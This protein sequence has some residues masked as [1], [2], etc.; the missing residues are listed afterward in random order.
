MSLRNG[1][2]DEGAA[3]FQAATQQLSSPLPSQL[4]FIIPGKHSLLFEQSRNQRH[5]SRALLT[6]WFWTI[7]PLIPDR[8]AQRYPP[9]ALTSANQKKSKSF[10]EKYCYLVFF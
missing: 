4:L 6:W 8:S 3:H 5:D 1:R 10:K 7:L 2:S 9:P